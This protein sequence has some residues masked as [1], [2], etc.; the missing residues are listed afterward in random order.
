MLTNHRLFSSLS[1]EGLALKLHFTALISTLQGPGA[2]QGLNTAFSDWK[3]FGVQWYDYSVMEAERLNRGLCPNIKFLC[4]VTFWLTVHIL[5][6]ANRGPSSRHL[7]WLQQSAFGSTGLRS[8]H[9]ENKYTNHI[10]SYY[11]ATPQ[12][13]HEFMPSP[14]QNRCWKSSGTHTSALLLLKRTV[15][16]RLHAGCLCQLCFT[17]K[18]G[19]NYRSYKNWLMNQGTGVKWNHCSVAKAYLAL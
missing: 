14:N 12:S 18:I 13:P 9:S 16:I 7:F 3:A 15:D 10:M 5:T 11:A 6:S 1:S 17:L 2:G 19:L 4:S 8:R